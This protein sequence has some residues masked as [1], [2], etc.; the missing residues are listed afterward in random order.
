MLF[1]GSFELAVLRMSR[2]YDLS[3]NCVLYAETMLPQDAFYTNE[4]AEMRL[5]N[6][7]FDFA[8][9][10]AEMKLTETELALYSAVV[11]LS[12]GSHNLLSPLFCKY[13]FL[14]KH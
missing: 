4:T 13:F 10:I 2:Y 3:Q 1:S 7:V 12:P 6:F 14:C 11:L 9:S 8:R 5:V